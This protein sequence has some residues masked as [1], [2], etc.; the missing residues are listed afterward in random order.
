MLLLVACKT[1]IIIFHRITVMFNVCLVQRKQEMVAVH[2]VVMGCLEWGKT[3][4]LTPQ[5]LLICYELNF[6]TVFTIFKRFPGIT[7][8]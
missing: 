8:H 5:L 2:S 1:R 3:G 4:V 7:V 6:F